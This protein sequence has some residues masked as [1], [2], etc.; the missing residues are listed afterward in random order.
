MAQF[1]SFGSMVTVKAVLGSVRSAHPP[2]QPFAKNGGRTLRIASVGDVV[3]VLGVVEVVVVVVG[4]VVPVVV[5][6]PRS[7]KSF[8]TVVQSD[9]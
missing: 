9:F 4:M 5:G 2:L 3:V 1:E 8:R 7:S 6:Q